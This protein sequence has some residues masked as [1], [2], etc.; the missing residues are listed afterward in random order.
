MEE[1]SEAAIAYVPTPFALPL[2]IED[3]INETN[4]QMDV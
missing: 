4:M 2:P 1:A 3:A